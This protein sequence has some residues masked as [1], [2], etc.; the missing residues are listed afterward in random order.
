M[1]IQPKGACG[2]IGRIELHSGLAEGLKDL[3]GFSHIFVI[4]HFH[5]TTGVSLT[6][7]PFLDAQSHGLFA[8]RAP[9]RPNPIG[10]SVLRLRKIDGAILEV[11]G[12]DILDQTPVLD[13]KPYV[14]E[15]DRPSGQVTTGWL[16]NTAPQ[17]SEV[18]SDDRFNLT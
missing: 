11:E 4:Y 17:V 6:V 7:T 9:C 16:E 8:T 10:L 13:I 18:R 12:V 3:E 15:F 14:P 5:C 1:P 2:I